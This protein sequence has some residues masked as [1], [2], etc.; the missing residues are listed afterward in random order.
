[1]NQRAADQR[2]PPISEK[3]LRPS[4]TQQEIDAPEVENRQIP[5][6]VHR[7]VEVEIVRQHAAAYAGDAVRSKPRAKR[8][9]DNHN[10]QPES[11]I[12]RHRDPCSTAL[13]KR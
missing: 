9:A 7:E 10:Q 13:R 11:K 12:I 5:T 1:M 4:Y 2:P 6:V 3:N 8:R